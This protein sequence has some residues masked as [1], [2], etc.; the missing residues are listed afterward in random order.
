M[1]VHH[2]VF[3]PDS[4]TYTIAKALS[5][6]GH[7]VTVCIVDPE[8]RNR[9]PTY[10]QERLPRIPRLQLESAWAPKSSTN[11]DRLI[12]QVFPRPLDTLR[13]AGN[14][15]AHARH[16][17]LV[18]IGDRNQA[19][20]AAMKWQWAEWR[21]LSAWARK[22]DRILYKDGF[23]ALDFH[24]LRRSRHAVGF[25]VHSQFL[26]D[27]ELFAAIH[28]NDWRPASARDILVNFLGSQDPEVRRRILDSIR[29]LMWGMGSVDG[30]ARP[31]KSLYWHEY[32][33]DA[34]AAL[35]PMDFLG[36]LS[37][38]D[39]TLC[40]RG[41]SL[42]THR[43]IEALLR[44]SVPVL[45]ETELDLYGVPLEHGKNCIAV[46][47]EDWRRTVAELSDIEEGKIVEMR[48]NIHAMLG[49]YLD[50]GVLSKRIR[51]RLGV[52]S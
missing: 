39:F 36:I 29:P 24:C 34:P 5:Y 10:A 35:K 22:I 6:G 52:E 44:G 3:R 25:D 8:Y 37:R 17:S 48:R 18:T 20:H 46:R 19:W 42:V 41:Y 4:L 50:Y 30:C 7:D 49:T 9:H 21:S 28:L 51:S 27:A 14:L 43:P 38:S 31:G 45:S 16:V 13:S 12:V 33:D 2:L 47:A 23:F 32:S 11:I 40:P 26:D 1:E 15:A